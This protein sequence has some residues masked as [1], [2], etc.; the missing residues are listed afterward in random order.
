M[1]HNT[2]YIWSQRAFLKLHAWHQNAV[3]S[4][5]SDVALLVYPCPIIWQIRITIAFHQ[6][7]RSP[8]S[9]SVLFMQF[10]CHV[11]ILTMM[12]TVGVILCMFGC[13]RQGSILSIARTGLF[14]KLPSC[15]RVRLHSRAVRVNTCISLRCTG[16]DDLTTT[17]QKTT[18]CVHIRWDIPQY[19]RQQLD[20][21]QDN[22]V[23]PNSYSGC[24]ALLVTLIS[25]IGTQIK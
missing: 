10:V 11:H 24:V 6:A 13:F 25:N 15:Q 23:T 5:T 14:K 18:N 19:H 7:G 16:T 8:L 17:K 20:V 21:T 12:H 2:L 1:F 22:G 9:F 3:W 4:I